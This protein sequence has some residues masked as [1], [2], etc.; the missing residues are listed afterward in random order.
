MT[1]VAVERP[2]AKHMGAYYTDVRVAEF[3]VRWAIRTSADV[4]L[5]P[6]F[7]GGVFLATAAEL[8]GSLGGDASSQ[9]L[10]I[11]LSRETFV[12]TMPRNSSWVS[13][14]GPAS[15]DLSSLA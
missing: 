3:L 12:S 1:I 5:D 11:E 4:V 7:G 10:G 14:N 9:V 15:W 13:L 6:S 2:D 8:V